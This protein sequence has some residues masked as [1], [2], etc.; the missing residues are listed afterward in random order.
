MGI[1]FPLFPLFSPCFSPLDN[2]LH[3]CRSFNALQGVEVGIKRIR[4]RGPPRGGKPIREV[5]DRF[6]DSIILLLT[7]SERS[8]YYASYDEHRKIRNDDDLRSLQ[9]P[10]PALREAPQ[11]LAAIPLPAMQ[12]HL[13][14]KSSAHL[15]YDV[16]LRGSR[17]ARAAIVA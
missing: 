16:H 7:N 2:P 1:S 4:I 13:Y 17:R 10:L 3:Y 11:W 12:A 9:H 15:G 8:L 5:C 14:G 6:P